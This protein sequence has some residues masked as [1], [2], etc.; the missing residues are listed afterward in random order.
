MNI[1][2]FTIDFKSFF[3]WFKGLFSWSDKYV[4]FVDDEVNDFP[5]IDSLK[6]QNYK[7]DTLNDIENIDCPHISRAKIIFI[8]YKWVWK[9]FTK[10]EQWIW[11]IKALKSKY[12]KKKTIILFSASRF[13]LDKETQIADDKIAKNASLQ[14]FIAII[15][16]YS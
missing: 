9:K 13:S 7:I 4:L 8:D 11:L 3:Q 16:K 6:E 14:E 10:N 12:W 1:I 5:V 2:W 15:Q